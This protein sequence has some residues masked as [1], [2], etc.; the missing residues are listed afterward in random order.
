MITRPQGCCAGGF[1]QIDH[2]NDEHIFSVD[3]TENPTGGIRECGM[4]RERVYKMSKPARTLC[5][6]S[7]HHLGHHEDGLGISRNQG[8]EGPEGKQAIPCRDERWSGVGGGVRDGV[9]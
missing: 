6:R 4:I 3:I 9:V 7:R 2:D 8:K 1:G 5:V